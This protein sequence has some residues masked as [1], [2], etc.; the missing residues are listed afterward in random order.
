[1][2]TCAFSFLLAAHVFLLLVWRLLLFSLQVSVAAGLFLGLGSVY[3]LLSLRLDSGAFSTYVT[4]LILGEFSAWSWLFSWTNPDAPFASTVAACSMLLL[5]IIANGLRIAFA[6]VFLSS[7]VF[8]PL[9]QEPVSRLWYGAMDSGKPI[10]TT[11]FG[12]LGAFVVV[13]RILAR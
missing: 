6:L 11:R 5:D 7:F 8:R 13:G 9:I 12:L 4:D 3:S 2:A 10:F 1:M